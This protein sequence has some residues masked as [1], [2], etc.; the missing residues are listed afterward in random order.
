MFE[1][2]LNERP[3]WTCHEANGATFGLNEHYDYVWLTNPEWARE[4]LVGQP[5][6]EPWVQQRF[7]VN[8]AARQ[9]R[10]LESLNREIMPELLVRGPAW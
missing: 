6:T 2:L 5:V 9:L 1:A 3:V 4:C 10:E 8:D 7:A